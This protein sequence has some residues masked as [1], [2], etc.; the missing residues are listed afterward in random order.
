V[1]LLLEAGASTK[2]IELPIGYDKID[3]LLRRAASGQR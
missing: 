2:G 1:R 3:V